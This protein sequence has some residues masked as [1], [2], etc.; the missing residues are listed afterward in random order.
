MALNRHL[1]PSLKGSTI[2]FTPL[3]FKLEKVIP[4]YSHL[5]PHTIHTIFML[6]YVDHIIIRGNS[7]THILNLISKLHDKFTLKQLG[8][9]DYFLA[10]EVSHYS[11]GCLF[12]SQTKY[13]RDLPAKTN[14]SEAMSIP[15]PMVY[16]LKLIKVG[17]DYHQDPA[18]YGSVVRALQH[19]AITRPKIKFDVSIVC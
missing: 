14:M 5:S 13:M 3:A 19:A 2:F 10:I 9:H 7:H 1:V 8:H 18:N 11:N 4:L 12:L 6:V 16:N 15:T 17:V